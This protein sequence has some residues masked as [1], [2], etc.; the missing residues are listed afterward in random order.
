MK[1][2]ITLHQRG[3]RKRLENKRE[4]H[5]S[6]LGRSGG[7][8]AISYGRKCQNER[9]DNAGAPV[10]IKEKTPTKGRLKPRRERVSAKVKPWGKHWALC[11]KR[12]RPRKTCPRREK[13]EQEKENRLC[14]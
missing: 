11:Q 6:G 7:G 2:G 3:Q 12:K 1:G 5:R 14:C 8:K 13:E 4:R 10:K 9:D